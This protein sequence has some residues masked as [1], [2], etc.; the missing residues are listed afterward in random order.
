LHI[1]LMT[2]TAARVLRREANDVGNAA[3]RML[4]QRTVPE[5]QSWLDDFYAE[6]ATFTARQWLPV[7][8][9]YAGLVADEV[10]REVGQPSDPARYDGF[11][12]S[13]AE[14]LGNRQAQRSRA[15]L[16]EILAEFG[17]DAQS[18]I[19]STMLE[20]RTERPVGVGGEE[21]VRSGNAFAVAL[22]GFAG[23]RFLRW[24]AMGK[25]C[26]YCSR[27]D[28]KVVGITQPFLPAGVPFAND[29]PNGALTPSRNIG[30][31]PAHRGCLPGDSLVLTRGGIAASSERWFDGDLVVIQTAAGYE[32]SCT[33]NHPVLTDTG[34]VAAGALNVGDYVISDRSV[35]WE[36]GRNV[37]SQN[38]PALIHDVV[39][40]VGGASNV[41]TMPMPTTAEDFHGD[42]AN[43]VIAVIRTN[44][45]LLDMVATPFVEQLGEFSFQ[46]G[47]ADPSLLAGQS[48]G[49]K[50][51]K[52]VRFSNGSLMGG[53]DLCSSVLVGSAFPDEQ[54]S[55]GVATWSDASFQQMPADNATRDAELLG[56]GQFGVAGQVFAD[57]VIAVK[58]NSFHGLVYNLETEKGYYIANGIVVHNCDCQV[59]AG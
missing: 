58:F 38:V 40:S 26:A 2:D 54:L 39:K 45:D 31:A 35:D 49:A 15:R 17:E 56:Q 27:L 37:H 3:K 29:A 23:V 59:I 10:E 21:S 28:G 57:E 46:S 22:Y 11:I 4:G 30:H 32:L 6:H 9:A 48:A 13:Y 1:G 55:V 18:E 14:Q 53:C 51:L 42:G 5:F 25:T 33:P 24:V 12:A 41:M 52:T 19:E 43:S 44:G 47:Y 34:W 7:L 20:W 50:R 8:Q 16:D 36:S